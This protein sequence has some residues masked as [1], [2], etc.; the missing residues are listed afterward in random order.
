MAIVSISR[1]QHRRGLRA[2][3]PANLNEA[4]LGWCIDTRQ[5]FIGNGNTFTGNSQILTQWSPNDTI[6]THMYVGDTGV[7]A[8]GSV[9]RTLGSILDDTL[10]VKDYGAVGDGVTDDTAAI[11]QAIVDEW[12]R[13]PLTNLK[14]HN[15]INFPAGNYLVSSTILLY[16]FISLVGEGQ[17]RTQ[18][19][20]ASGATGPVMCTADSLGQTGANIGTNGAELPDSINVIGMNIDGSAD[21]GGNNP[22]ILLQRCSG[23]TI[24]G[25]KLINTWV[26]GDGAG[27]TN[28]GVTIESL[29]SAISTSDIWITGCSIRSC[30]N[31]VYVSDPVIRLNIIGN[32]LYNSYNAV[33]LGTSAY[34]GPSYVTI[35]D[36][37]VRDLDNNGL[38]IDT[39]GFVSSVNNSYKNIG[40]PS[41]MPAIVW[42]VAC[43]NCQSIGDVFDVTDRAYRVLNNNPGYNLI[44]DPQQTELVNNAPTPHIDTI[45]PNQVNAATGISYNLANVTNT[46]TAFIDYAVSLDTYRKSGRITVI[47]DGTTADL[48]DASTELNNDASVV[49]SVS[50]VPGV[51]LSINYTNTDALTGTLSWIQTYWS[52]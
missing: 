18:I 48:T 30:E 26:T 2:D 12:A 52:I 37:S 28:H 40:D 43:E 8:V 41:N 13:A 47:S 17:G 15:T 36:N 21:I 45:L 3:L 20:L 39:V 24:S 7:S 32:N 34:G 22:V 1:L 31:G 11:Q 16:P 50:T 44:F 42:S 10:N 33:T 46:F 38:D 14:G 4:E 49:F 25:C 27:N 6:I 9:V 5:L 51:S 19:T 23:I 29:G 35:Q